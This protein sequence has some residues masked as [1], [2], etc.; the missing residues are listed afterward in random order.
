MCQHYWI[1]PLAD[2]PTS[3]GVCQKCHDT[4]EFLNSIPGN[5]NW[6][7]PKERTEEE[8]A[9][10]VEVFEARRAHDAQNIGMPFSKES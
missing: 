2:G 5:E 1:L 6:Y 7:D 8:K 9:A 10:Q 3:T 4:K